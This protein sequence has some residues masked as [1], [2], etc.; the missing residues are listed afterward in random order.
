VEKVVARELPA[1]ELKAVDVVQAVSV[2]RVSAQRGVALAA[3]PR[4]VELR[5]VSVAQHVGVKRVSV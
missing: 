5:V 4:S 1:V 3:V 2:G